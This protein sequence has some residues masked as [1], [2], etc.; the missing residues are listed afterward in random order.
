MPGYGG[1]AL[2]DGSHF[3]AAD[4]RQSYLGLWEAI[5]GPGSVELNPWVWAV[6]FNRIEGRA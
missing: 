6:E 3:H 5:N 2:A 4:P 1:F